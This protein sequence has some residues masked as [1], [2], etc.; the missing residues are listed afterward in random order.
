MR[1]HE[2]A[3]EP[4]PHRPLMIGG[5]ALSRGTS[6][7]PAVA[8]ISG[9][10]A[11]KAKRGEQAARA[12]VNDCFLLRGRKRIFRQRNRKNLIRPHRRIV[13]AGAVRAGWS[14]KHVETASG[15]RVPKAPEAH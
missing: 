14:I 6:I 5:I 7:M 11:A 3:H 15:L 8:W 13:S 9:I 1:N 12:R 2:R 4:R 10:Q